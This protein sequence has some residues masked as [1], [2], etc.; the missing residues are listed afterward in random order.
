MIEDKSRFAELD[1]LFATEGTLLDEDKLQMVRRDLSSRLGTEPYRSPV[2][3]TQSPLGEL[4]RRN[5]VN[6]M[7][8]L[9]AFE[10]HEFFK[11]LSANLR[12]I[13]VDA[14]SHRAL[15]R[16][17]KGP[18]R[19]IESDQEGY[20]WARIFMEGIHN[21]MAVRNRLRV[22]KS[23]FRNY[24][25]ETLAKKD[26]G[27]DVL[28]VAA[29]SNRGMAEVVAEL[30]GAANNRL[31]VRLVDYEST[32]GDDA[33]ALA[34]SLGIRDSVDF[35]QEPYVRTNRYLTDY[36]PDFIE[37][38]G[39]LDYVNDERMEKLITSLH[40]SLADGGTLLYSNITH[41]DEQKFTHGIVG[42]YPMV[43]RSANDLMNFADRAG[44]NP[45]KTK[46]ITEPLGVYN[47]VAATK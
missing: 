43:Y 21:S 30:N 13:S 35:I 11:S 20:E 29:G 47:L 23:E 3:E 18:D 44:F 25:T 36:H 40:D 9:G 10:G 38:V 24:I 7:L 45:D 46:L 31:K 32:A 39:L 22:V 8:S 42:W 16:M 1:S 37:V 33:L 41:N 6:W 4:N 15:E 17:Y 28:S 34:Q 19:A 27:V 12:Q 26:G 5:L 14:A 2:S